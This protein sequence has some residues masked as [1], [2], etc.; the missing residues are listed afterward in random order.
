MT[1]KVARNM[2]LI[3]AK[4]LRGALAETE[5]DVDA[6]KKMRGL[7]LL[8]TALG[9]CACGPSGGL[10]IEPGMT[11][12]PM[13]VDGSDADSFDPSSGSG[14]SVGLPPTPPGSTTEDGNSG[15]PDEG[16]LVVPAQSVWRYTT[17]EPLP[18]WTEASFDDL[19]WASGAGPLGA[20]ASDIRTQVDATAPGVWLRHVF[21]IKKP[22][23]EGEEL[24]VHLRR[25]DGA[26][27][28][29]NGEIVVASNLSGNSTTFAAEDAAGG[30]EGKR[31]FRFAVPGSALVGGENVLAVSLHRQAVDNPYAFD[32]QLELL[33]PPVEVYLQFRTRTYDGKY[34]TRNAGAVWI[35]EPGGVFVRTLMVWAEVRRE[36]LVRWQEASNGN[37]VDARTSATRK[38]H[39][40]TVLSWDLKDANGAMVGPG[41]YIVRAEFTEENSNKGAP[42]GPTLEVPLAVGEATAT[43]LPVATG[44]RDVTVLGP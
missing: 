42:L 10:A 21:T 9:Y 44:F 2:R 3:I 41:D 12:K 13:G 26:A 38:G 35:E 22:S 1:S 39:S 29:L 8:F 25:A 33:Q 19:E 18:G 40:T 14:E 4:D 6:T 31:Y 30:D 43:S 16:P 17:Q 32:L 27:V 34:S 23:A 7:G 11:P 28:Y 36:H 24:I 15:G 37:D 5:V 20:G